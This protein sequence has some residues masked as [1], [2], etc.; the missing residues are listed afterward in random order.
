MK[1]HLLSIIGY[2]CIHTT[3]FTFNHSTAYEYYICGFNGFNQF[4]SGLI[5]T[6]LKLIRKAASGP[7]KLQGRVTRWKPFQTKKHP[8]PT[9]SP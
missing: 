8:S 9:K 1:W 3:H 2:F 7:S 6:R 5:G 4:I